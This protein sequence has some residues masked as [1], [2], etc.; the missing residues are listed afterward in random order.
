MKLYSIA[1]GSSGN[2]T[3]IE[4]ENLRIL[5][6][7]GISFKKLSNAF[8]S[9]NINILHLTHVL[10][11]HEHVDHIRGMETLYSN[12]R[13]PLYTSYGTA[14]S[15]KYL[16]ND[17]FVDSVRIIEAFSP[18]K[19]GSMT[20]TPI[21]LSHDAAEPLGFIFETSNIKLGYVT[22]TGYIR[23]TLIEPLSNCDFYYFEAN[24]DPIMLKNSNR[25]YP[26]IHRILTERGHLS[27]EDSAYYLSKMMGPRTKGIIMAHISDECNSLD[28]IKTTYETVLK[29]NQK[30]LD[31]LKVYYA[32]QTPLEVIE[33]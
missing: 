26:T 10:I 33:L 24:H 9:E 27:N 2:A 11:T 4:H 20:I 23:E 31:S 6:D 3:Y 28:K 12:I 5:V 29:A 17:K 16:D 30:S 8:L 1:S 19:L 32:S 22:D 21:P 13:V 15:M 7:A 18:F 25:P 14:K